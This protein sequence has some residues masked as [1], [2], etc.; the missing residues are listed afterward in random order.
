MPFAS[1]F[2]G[3]PP[4]TPPTITALLPPT[5]APLSPAEDHPTFISAFSISRAIYRHDVMRDVL[6]ALKSEL[7]LTLESSGVPATVIER[8]QSFASPLLPF[9]KAPAGKKKLHDIGASPSR[10]GTWVVNAD[11]GNDRPEEMS[12]KFQEFYVELANHTRTEFEEQHGEALE[13]EK[14]TKVNEVIQ[15]VESTLCTLFYDR[16]V[17]SMHKRIFLFLALISGS[18]FLPSNSDDTSHDEALSSHIAALNL[19]DLG[20]EHLDVDVGSAGSEID[21]VIRACGESKS[22]LSK[23]HAS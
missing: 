15:A 22:R 3:K 7:T 8:V 2:G 18:L 20:L 5:Q 1:L 9:V 11:A 13:E 10:Q 6:G 16:C 17:D 12:E 4:S 23:V 19:L 14:E 21:V